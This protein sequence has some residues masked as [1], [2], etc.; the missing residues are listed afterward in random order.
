MSIGS[1][2]AELSMHANSLRRDQ[3]NFI[4]RECRKRKISARAAGRLIGLDEVLGLFSD[5]WNPPQ[6]VLD[7]LEAAL[8]DV[9][10]LQREPINLVRIDSEDA[11]R[12][13]SPL[14]VAALDYWRSGGGV[15]SAATH[16]CLVASG[17]LSQSTIIRDTSSGL[18]VE[19][20]SDHVPPQG[21][22]RR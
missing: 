7:E 12:A 15:W 22:Y 1:R 16:A 2:I 18:Y 21:Q 20:R 19:E 8:F 3:M 9:V 4:L 10:G 6:S 11:V 17:A 14:L 5:T 13:R